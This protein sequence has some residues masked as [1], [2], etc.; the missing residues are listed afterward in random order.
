MNKI[1]IND[2]VIEVPNSWLEITFEQFIRF[3]KL[4]NGQKTEKEL[5]EEY[6]DLDE[7]IKSLQISI[8]N[9]NFNTKVA[10]FWSGL[11]EEE[12]ALCEIDQVEQIIKSVDFLNEK[13]QPIALDKFKFEGE[14]YYLPNKGMREQNFGTYIEAEQVELNNKRIE[15]GNLDFLPRQIAI[16]CKREGEKPGLIDEA[17]IKER[18]KIFNRLDMATVWDVAF[19][20]QQ[21]EARLMTLFLTYL[22]TEG[23]E[24]QQSQLKTQS[25]ATDG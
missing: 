8:E 3:T 25:Q 21:H 10:C 4:V 11:T 15:N 2:N 6:E 9:V 13:Y 18:E 5:M 12:I 14:T 23:T 24:K 22:Q 7:S 16:L 20:L 17:H 19:F 1:E